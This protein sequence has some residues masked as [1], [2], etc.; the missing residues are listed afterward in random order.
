MEA[1]LAQ[2]VTTVTVSEKEHQREVLCENLEVGAVTFLELNPKSG[3][4]SRY[5]TVIRGWEES[6]F[7]LLDKP[8]LNTGLM[9]RH[10]QPCALRFIR[11]GV[12]WGFYSTISDP[13][14]DRA[15]RM[16]RLAWP[17][18]IQHIHLRRHERVRVSIP[19]SF[20]M[21]DGNVFEAA[22]QDL[23]SGGC[24]I[25]SKASL[26]EGMKIWLTFMLPDGDQ[27]EELPV[28]VKNHHAMKGDGASFGC[29]FADGK[30]VERL[31]IAMFVNRV[32]TIER[33]NVTANA[34]VILLLG[35]EEDVH[36]L[37]IAMGDTPFELYRPNGIVDLFHQVRMHFPGAVLIGAVQ[38]DMSAVDICHVLRNT[39]GLE[40]VQVVIFGGKQEQL[41]AKA[42]D[43]GASYYLKDLSD[44]SL[45]KEIV[46]N[47][48]ATAPKDLE[49]KD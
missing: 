6:E 29:A 41:C 24:R 21:K 12:V 27:V 17:K 35:T 47:T 5:K 33:G 2:E 43:A 44:S 4:P 45:L 16:I 20:S 46:S 48:T 37:K 49:A 23:S 25:L 1:A 34:P 9:L 15:D 28:E 13:S 19:C 38:Q 39:K 36:I 7:L 26:W 30:D 40:S 8:G 18:E 42:L 31:R 3:C 10:G 14:P 32:I 11:D 22:I